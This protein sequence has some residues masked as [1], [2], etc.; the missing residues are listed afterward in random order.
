MRAIIDRLR[1]LLRAAPEFHAELDAAI[2]DL[3][4]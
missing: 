3:E 1:A 4:V 2:C